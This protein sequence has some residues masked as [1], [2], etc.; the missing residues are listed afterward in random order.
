MQWF[1]DLKVGVKLVSVFILVALIA[2]VV[3]G[4]GISKISQ[5]TYDSAMM[6]EK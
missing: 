1:R 5:I 2:A 4:I 6:Y 3:G